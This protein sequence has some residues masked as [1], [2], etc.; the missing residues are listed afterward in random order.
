MCFNKTS[1]LCSSLT[2][3]GRL[4]ALLRRSEEWRC[5]NKR[6]ICVHWGFEPEFSLL[7]VQKYY[8][9]MGNVKIIHFFQG[10]VSVSDEGMSLFF[11]CL[12][13]GIHLT[14]VRLLLFIKTKIF[15]AGESQK[16][17]WVS[18]TLVASGSFFPFYSTQ[19]KRE[20]GFMAWQL[21]WCIFTVCDTLWS[22]SCP[23]RV[24]I[25]F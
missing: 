18:I 7:R 10:S 24:S 20:K 13:G 4:V 22:Q 8:I 9:N 19:I 17:R 23:S 25:H 1:S 5:A 6:L 16:C 2:A 21:T 11:T 15:Q 12:P 14:S 3:E